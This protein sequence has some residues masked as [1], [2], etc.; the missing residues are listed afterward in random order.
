MANTISNNTRQKKSE[1]YTEE[2]ALERWIDELAES[3]GKS[4]KEIAQLAIV[5]LEA[6][7]IQKGV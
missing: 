1:G 6:E 2:G 7:R 5:K 4:R 3:S